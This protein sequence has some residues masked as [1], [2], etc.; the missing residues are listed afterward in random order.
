MNN[1]HKTKVRD[2]PLIRYALLL[3]AILTLVIAISLTWNLLQV[4]KEAIGMARAE[5]I[6]VIQTHILF[7]RWNANHGG[8]YVP[9]TEHTPPNPFLTYVSE[10]DI[11]S[12][13]G[14]LL[15]L[16]N[17]AY[18]TRQVYEMAARE[19]K[20]KG[21]LTSLNPLNPKNAPDTWEIEALTA[22][23]YGEIVVSSIEEIEGD[24]YI[25]VM[26]SLIAEKSCLK[27]HE[28][29][30]YKQGDI[31]GGISVEVPL[32]P[33]FASQKDLI[34]ALWLGHS[35]FLLIS[36]CG[37]ILGSKKLGHTIRER[38]QVL[39]KLQKSE[40]SLAEAQRI[41]HIGNWDL[42]LGANELKWSDEIYRIFGLKP[43]EFGAT[44]EAFL[45]TIHPDDRAFVN[46]AYKE[47]VKNNTPYDI[48]HRITRPDGEVRYVNE[49]AED[50]KNEK[51]ETIRSVG[52]V[53]DITDR[54]LAEEELSKNEHCC[55][56][57]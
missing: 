30:G 54:K 1:S 48:V 6:I 17:P 12:P 13:S 15:T 20:L 42:D 51:G 18:M 4:K 5:A 16:I 22:F 38:Y 46:T 47:S 35:I 44:Y 57:L 34:T 31:K 53:Q 40:A 10:R 7:R 14:R 55:A 26:Q 29:Q 37:I 33:H 3:A 56:L 2:I 43:Q 41:A 27:C 39:D 21:H 52:T 25:R 45:G 36:F 32:Q 50:I 9:V 19:K 8:V 11:S 23:E 24:K 28:Q 49:K